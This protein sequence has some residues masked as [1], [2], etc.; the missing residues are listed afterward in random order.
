MANDTSSTS[1]GLWFFLAASAVTLCVIDAA[2]R[3]TLNPWE[4]PLIVLHD[5]GKTFFHL[6]IL[7]A[8]VLVLGAHQVWH[9][10]QGIALAPVHQIAL[11]ILLLASIVGAIA[12]TRHSFKTRLTAAEDIA[13]PDLRENLATERH[14]WRGALVAEAARDKSRE[15]GPVNTK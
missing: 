2:L 14:Q 5:P 10:R 1:N 7:P 9:R 3:T 4:T 15:L 11:V 8:V 13:A 12:E 6:F